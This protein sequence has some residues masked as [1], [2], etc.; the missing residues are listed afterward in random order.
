MS[1]PA[2]RWRTG[3][4][5]HNRKPLAGR[6]GD[7]PAQQVLAG[8]GVL[9]VEE[10]AIDQ[11]PGMVIDDQKQPGPH[12]PLPAGPGHPRPDQHIADPPLVRPGRLIPSIGLRLGGQRLAVQPGAAQLAAD[13]PLMHPDPVPVIQDRGDLGGRP[14]RQLQPQRGGLGEQLRVGADRA[15]IS[16]RRGLERLQPARAPGPQPP[17]DGAPRIPPRRPVRMGVGAGGDLADQRAALGGG[18]PVPG[19]LGDHR[20]AVQCDRFLPLGVHV[21]LRSCRYGGTGG[22]KR[23]VPAIR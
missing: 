8:T 1:W 15:G 17:V 3:R 12:R 19:R 2:T 6:G 18:Q 14:A 22:M 23:R 13:G 9:P 16:P 7:R 4:R 5:C 10:P 11:Q 21:F 20:P